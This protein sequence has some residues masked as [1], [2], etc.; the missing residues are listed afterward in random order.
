MHKV[1][2][3]LAGRGC[4]RGAGHRRRCRLRRPTR[5]GRAHGH[6]GGQRLDPVHHRSDSGRPR[7]VASEA[8]H[9]GQ[10]SRPGRPA[11]RPVGRPGSGSAAP[12][13]GP[14][15]PV[16]ARWFARTH[17]YR[18]RDATAPGSAHAR[19][20]SY[21]HRSG[22]RTVT[23]RYRPAESRPGEPGHPTGGAGRSG[24]PGEQRSGE[25][26]RQ[27]VPDRRRV[28]IRARLTTGATDRPSLHA[29]HDV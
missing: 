11:H 8:G 2:V 20:G 21:R 27:P 26:D 7:P 22:R 28:I 29:R 15:E 14:A 25:T 23:D 17:R 5:S 24:A 13:T 18:A 4:S 19:P 9:S 10:G 3:A 12:G 1:T 6:P 16:R